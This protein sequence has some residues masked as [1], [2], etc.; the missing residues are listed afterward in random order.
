MALQGSVVLSVL[1]E[2]LV[3]VLVPAVLVAAPVAPLLE[4]VVVALPLE[5]LLAP[6]DSPPPPPQAARTVQMQ[7][8]EDILGE[9]IGV[10]FV[11]GD[12]AHSCLSY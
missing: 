3:S 10:Y 8:N 2:V 6:A 12:E 5:P 11:S 9:R 4:E 1:S 7:T